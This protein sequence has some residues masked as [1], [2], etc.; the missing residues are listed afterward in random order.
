MKKQIISEAVNE[1][2]LPIDTGENQP[3]VICAANEA[4]FT[5]VNY[6]EP[7]TQYTVGWKD[8]ENLDALLDSIAPSVPVGRRFEFKKAT[9]AEA[10]L[11]ET[12]D[13][14]A[15]GSSFKRVEYTGSSVNE[16]TLNKGLTIRLDKDDLLDDMEEE[17]SVG[18]LMQRLSRNE[19]RRVLGLIDA[20]STNLAKVWKT[21]GTAA[22]ADNDLRASL[23]LGT[24]SSGI[25]PNIA[26]F[27][28]A[29]WDLRQNSYEVQN[30]PYAGRA[31]AMTQQELAAKLMVDQVIIAKARYQ[32][33]L[34]AKS[35]V[36][37]T[38]TVLLYLAYQ[39]ASKDDPSNIKRFVTP[40]GTRYRVFRK[41][42][43]KFIDL[44]VEHYSNAVITSTLG[45]R[46]LTVSAT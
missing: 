17:R 39:G 28:E 24:D 32:S 12:D 16:K 41:E 29:A 3:G 37:T 25:R 35:L 4:R 42:S 14:R 22:N 30:T 27:S 1:L 23:I 45:I 43:D 8:P 6:S 21:D 5:S 46:K 26:L 18:R 44:S 38:L 13:V 40:V 34:T 33:S 7:L 10:F 2:H 31:A 20:A 36:Q 15:I 11:S 19:L 9:N